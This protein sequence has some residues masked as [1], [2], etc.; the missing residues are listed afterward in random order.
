MLRSIRRPSPALVVACLALLIALSGTSIAAISQV[1]R[2][3]VG[4]AQLKDNA[5]TSAKL[6][7]NAVNSEKVRNRSLLAIDFARGQIPQGPAG[8]TGPAGPAGP[9]GAAGP[10]GPAGPQGRWAYVSSTGSVL[11]QSG[12]ITV[13][14]SATGVFFVT[15]PGATVNDK[16]VLATGSRVGSSTDY[17]TA[18]ACGGAPLGLTC[19]LSNN[20]NTVLVNGYDATGTADDT[21]FYVM[22]V[23]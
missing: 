1:A 16:P 20:T 6:K 2:N 21:A 8:P 14:R 15:F 10:A 11:A 5:V 23:A 7:N 4:T 17:V 13:N 9:T 12:G 22:V 19:A 18:S 3:S